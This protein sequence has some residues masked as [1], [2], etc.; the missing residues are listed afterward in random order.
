[1]HSSLIAVVLCIFAQA[2]LACIPETEAAQ[3]RCTD[4]G[5]HDQDTTTPALASTGLITTATAGT[6][7]APV[8]RAAPRVAAQPMKSTRAAAGRPCC[9]PP[10]R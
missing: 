2:S 6:R 8:P 10:W 4:P 1:M 7:D 3:S 9:W 5:P